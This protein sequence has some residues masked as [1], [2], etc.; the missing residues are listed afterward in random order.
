ME[1]EVIIFLVVFFTII[2]IV[3]SIIRVFGCRKPS[4]KRIGRRLNFENISEEEASRLLKEAKFVPIGSGEDFTIKRALRR[5]FHDYYMIVGDLYI[6]KAAKKWAWGYFETYCIFIQTL[7]LPTFKIKL[8]DPDIITEEFLRT[9]FHQSLYRSD[10]ECLIFYPERNLIIYNA[11]GTAGLVIKIQNIEK[12]KDLLTNGRMLLVA[13]CFD[14]GV[15]YELKST[16]RG[17]F[18]KTDYY[19]P[20]FDL[21]SYIEDSQRLFELFYVYKD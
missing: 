17:F 13:D 16:K 5:H 6:G 15:I 9:S 14:R 10:K 8:L 19:C 2:F 20:L 12:A 4:F 7:K 11:Y 1:S 18:T 3:F 21:S